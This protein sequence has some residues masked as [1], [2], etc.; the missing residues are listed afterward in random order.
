M[1][2]PARCR[3]CGSKFGVF[4]WRHHCVVCQGCRCSKCLSQAK[5]SS[6][7]PEPPYEVGAYCT[8]CSAEHIEPAEAQL[9]RAKNLAS[10]MDDWSINYK[11]RVPFDPDGTQNVFTSDSHED[12]DYALWEMKVRAALQGYDIVYE[13]QYF[14]HT[15]TETLHHGQ[16]KNGSP[17]YSTRRYTAWTAMGVGAHRTRR[18]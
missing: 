10:T 1:T 6:L 3:Q 9:V 13:V 11:G 14:K 17:I 5:P 4:R 12:R 2:K 16:R 18:G 15:G 7:W 8:A